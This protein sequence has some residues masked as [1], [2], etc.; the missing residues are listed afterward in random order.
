MHRPTFAILI[1]LICPAVSADVLLRES[2]IGYSTNSPLDGQNG[3]VGFKSEWSG[4]SDGPKI[5]SS[6]FDYTDAAGSSF[7]TEGNAVR[8]NNSRDSLTRD[9]TDSLF[10]RRTEVWAS[11]ALTGSAGGGISNVSFADELILGQGSNE[12]S[13]SNWSIFD[14]NG[15]GFVSSTI[16][17]DGDALFVARLTLDGGSDGNITSVL[18]W[19]NP[20]LSTPPDTATA[21]NPGGT[22]V[23]G[24]K[25]STIT[26]NLQ[27]G[28]N[29]VFIHDVRFGDTFLDVAPFQMGTPVPEPETVVV[30]GLGL[31][32]FAAVQRRRRHRAAS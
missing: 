23:S 14:K 5:A 1:A 19:I 31:L 8:G 13:S 29:D 18:A 11:F 10:D 16:A 21:F 9:T 22:A 12:N 27:N 15:G 28:D 4:S 7:L 24:P 32:I 2:F 3:G 6:S 30:M 25:L 17:A 26:F 20:L